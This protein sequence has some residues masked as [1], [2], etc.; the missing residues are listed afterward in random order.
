[1]G[2]VK[3]KNRGLSRS[4]DEDL[5]LLGRIINVRNFAY[6]I[7]A[8]FTNTPPSHTQTEDLWLQHGCNITALD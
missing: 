4:W 1:M 2:T 8:E 3:K 5:A 6:I 7:A